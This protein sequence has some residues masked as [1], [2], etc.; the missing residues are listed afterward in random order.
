MGQA[1]V[2]CCDGTSFENAYFKDADLELRHIKCKTFVIYLGKFFLLVSNAN[3]P[4]I[5]QQVS[6]FSDVTSI[7]S[8]LLATCGCCLRGG[9]SSQKINH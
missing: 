1:F 9:T 7:R 2:Q 3:S 5:L 6:A 4:F 8:T